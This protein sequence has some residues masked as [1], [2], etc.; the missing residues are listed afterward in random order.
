MV[1]FG[2]QRKTVMSGKTGTNKESD[3]FPKKQQTVLNVMKAYSVMMCLALSSQ[4][5]IKRLRPKVIDINYKRKKS[6]TRFL[7]WI[8]RFLM[9][10]TTRG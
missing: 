7:V 6:Q 9:V 5:T 3:R 4:V 2:C 10:I 8:I 1:C